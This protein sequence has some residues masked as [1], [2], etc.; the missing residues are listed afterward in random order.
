[1]SDIKS[2]DFHIPQCE[3]MKKYPE[4]LFYIGDTNLLNTPLVSIVGTRKPTQYTKELT[5]ELAHALSMAGVTIVSGA[6]MGVD[7]IAHQGAG[8]SKTIAV[9]GTGLDIRYPAINRALI[10]DIEQNGL[11]L[12]MFENGT[13]AT[14]Y[15]FPLRNELVVALGKVLIVT[16]ADLNSGTLRSVEYALKM[17]KEIYV[18]PHRLKESEGTQRLLEQN[19]AK[20][21]YDIKS[22]VKK[23]VEKESIS[24][25][26]IDTIE[27]YFLSNPLYD[28]AMALYPQKVFEYELSGKIEVKNGKVYTL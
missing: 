21:I 8:V 4:K 12:S 15:T 26:T 5:F 6:A 13:G 1:M 22:F 17:G 19:K 23:I 25:N 27:S 3:M 18:L 11:V 16:Q 2:V 10:Q 7:A 9:V 28:D 24:S 20:V 14:R